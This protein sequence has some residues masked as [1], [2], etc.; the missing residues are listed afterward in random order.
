MTEHS[1]MTL[2]D[3]ARLAHVR[4]PVVSMW[5][6]RAAASS[7]PFPPSQR[8]RGS[9]DWFDAAA[10]V[11]WLE[12][13]G[14]GNNP[15]ARA[16]AARFAAP[17]GLDH[18]H[19]TEAALAITALLSLRVMTGDDLADRSAEDLLT[20]AKAADPHDELL[21]REMAAKGPDLVRLAAYADQVADAAFTSAE[22]FEQLLADRA[23]LPSTDEGDSAVADPLHHLGTTLTLALARSLTSET[24]AYVDPTDAGSD[25]FLRAVRADAASAPDVLTAADD[26]ARGRLFRRRLRVHDFPSTRIETGAPVDGPA[27]VLAHH[28]TDGGP[29]AARRRT[30]T[31]I[32][33]IVLT[34]TDDQRAVVLAP[35]SLLVDATSDGELEQT[36]SQLLRVGRVRAMVRLPTGLA[37]RRPRQTLAI[38]VLGPDLSRHPVPE[39]R[40]AVIDVSDQQLSD[41]LVEQ[42]TD[43]VLACLAEPALASAHGYARARLVT[44]STVLAQGHGLL[45]RP[46][47]APPSDQVDPSDAILRIERLRVARRGGPD[48][49]DGAAIV[50]GGG[51]GA[52]PVR[53]D[54]A[55]RSRWVRV[56]AGNRQGFDVRDDGN[57]R[58]LGVPELCGDPVSAPPVG[59]RQVGAGQRRVDRLAFL[60]THDAARLS[61]AGDVVFCTSPRPRAVVDVD[62]GS[63]VQSPARVLRID[64]ATSEG[65]SPHAVA[66]AINAQP[67]RSRAWRG[68]TVPLVPPEQVVP[69]GGL[70]AAMHSERALLRRRLLEL[71]ELEDVTLRSVAAGAVMCH[72]STSPTDHSEDH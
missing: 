45:P 44:T 46:P 14:R 22:A 9:A 4:R 29:G 38:W 1:I 61:E 33:E 28:P 59:D 41:L 62:G 37:P 65:L 72:L 49:L 60:G 18:R 16:D 43:D 54:E 55:V 40:V 12:A 6:S 31:A 58:V 64:P 66:Q 8:G 7:L 25:L 39:R 48:V 68:W 20:L 11:D 63:A 51:S 5:R 2:G 23:R 17:A 67:A 34:L 30:L 69:L 26:T 57:V 70:V 42:I 3:I 71:D 13:T 10:V 27:V 24:P 35:A 52:R 47:A 36:R 50:P 53:I 32:D 15:D 19:D 21:V 56:I